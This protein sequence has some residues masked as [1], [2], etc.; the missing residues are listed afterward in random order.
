MEATYTRTLP[1]DDNRSRT[2]VR[3]ARLSLKRKC[4]FRL[5]NDRTV[6]VVYKGK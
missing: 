1:W 4:R 3:R 2:E 6:S 5:L